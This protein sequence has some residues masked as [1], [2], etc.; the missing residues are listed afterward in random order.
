MIVPILS[1]VC[2]NLT[3][4]S[5]VCEFDCVFSSLYESVFSRVCVNLTAF[6]RV[7]VNLTVPTQLVS[8]T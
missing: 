4:F 5:R 8:F 2:V 6:S 1:R 3:V 7:C